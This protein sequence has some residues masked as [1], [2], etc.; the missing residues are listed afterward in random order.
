MNSND[1]AK[2]LGISRQ[3]VHQLIHLGRIPA[4]R[5]GIAWDIDDEAVHARARNRPAAGKR[6][7][8]L[9]TGYVAAA[10][11]ARE[12]EVSLG[13]VRNWIHSGR[14]KAERHGRVFIVPTDAIPDVTRP[15]RG[16]PRSVTASTA[17]HSPQEARRSA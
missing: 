15:T 3:R 8:P 4:V 14:L 10:D 5:S 7:R 6:L 2:L 13:T 16:R 12:Y 17:S 1:A 9:P 11:V